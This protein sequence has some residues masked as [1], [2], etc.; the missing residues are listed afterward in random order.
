M[1]FKKLKDS[2]KNN[3]LGVGLGLSIC[4]EIIL[5]QG[6][7]VDIVSERDKGSDFI[8]NLKS[9]C[10]LDVARQRKARSQVQLLVPDSLSLEESNHRSISTNTLS[11][12]SN[13]NLTF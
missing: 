5:A 4:K 8:I 11:T 6:G 7:S 10:I 2:Q 1:N 13:A 12:L 3:H 9:K